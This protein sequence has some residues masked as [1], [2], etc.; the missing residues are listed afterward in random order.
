MR[1]TALGGLCLVLS[2]LA[3]GCTWKV[4]RPYR[5][6]PPAGIRATPIDYVESDA[7]DTLFESALV[8]QDPVIVV[9]TTHS[10]PDWGD[11]LNAWIAAWN[12]G[13]RVEAGGGKRTVRMQAPLPKV[14]IDG[15][16]IREFRLLVDDLMNRVEDLARARSAWWA[17]SKVR[18]RRVALLKPYNLRF[19]LDE[20]EH[21]QLIFFNGRYAEYYQEFMRSIVRTE[22]ADGWVRGVTCSHCKQSISRAPESPGSGPEH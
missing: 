17:E 4:T 12:M 11:R 7:F 5:D 20:Q 14:V 2:A 13:G 21:I 9:R 15:D 3:G 16:S 6:P 10:R 22:E 8:N 19:H 18:S 1:A